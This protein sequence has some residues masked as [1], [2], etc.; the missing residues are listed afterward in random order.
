MMGWIIPSPIVA[1]NVIVRHAPSYQLSLDLLMIR[2]MMKFFLCLHRTRNRNVERVSCVKLEN[3]HSVVSLAS[4]R[5]SSFILVYK[6]QKIS[7]KVNNT[8]TQK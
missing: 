4:F 3:F 1:S 5:I 7:Q 2:L 6:K 8:S